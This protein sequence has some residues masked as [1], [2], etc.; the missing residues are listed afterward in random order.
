M[1]IILL[2]ER[3][4]LVPGW[5]NQEKSVWEE[6]FGFPKIPDVNF[7]SIDISTDLE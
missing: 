1:G 4:S 6:P 3:H 7:H 2:G 5:K